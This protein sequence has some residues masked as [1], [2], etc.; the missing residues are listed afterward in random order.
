MLNSTRRVSSDKPVGP[1]DPDHPAKMLTPGARMSG[2]RISGVMVLGPREL[3]AATIG[4]DWIPS[5]V[6]SNKIVAVGLES[7]VTYFRISS[8]AFR[9]TKDAGNKCASATSSSPFAAVFVKTIPEAPASLT[10]EPF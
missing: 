10:T 6:P 4:D 5:F 3:K 7:E 8:P 2:F 1:A 9:P